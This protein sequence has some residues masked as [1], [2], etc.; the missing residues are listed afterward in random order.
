MFN[1]ENVNNVRQSVP[2]FHKMDLIV[3]DEVEDVLK[4]ESTPNNVNNKEFE[5]N[6]IES[7]LEK[8]EKI[9]F[10]YPIQTRT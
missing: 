2:I 10:S 5:R 7:I 6:L 3:E 9:L 8:A 4:R 1:E